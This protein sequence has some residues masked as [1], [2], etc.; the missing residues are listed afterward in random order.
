MS[1]NY[2]QSRLDDATMLSGCGSH[3]YHDDDEDKAPSNLYGM[4]NRNYH[5]LQWTEVI[6]DMQQFQMPDPE[7]TVFINT[8][9]ERYDVCNVMEVEGT[10]FMTVNDVADVPGGEPDCFLYCAHEKCASAKNYAKRYWE[11]LS[12]K[13]GS[14]NYIKSGAKGMLGD[15]RFKLRDDSAC[16]RELN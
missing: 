4:G 1:C 11:H 13:C 3:T 7:S 12:D 8:L 14:V 9:P 16:R 5:R 10:G 15:E 6:H 2:R